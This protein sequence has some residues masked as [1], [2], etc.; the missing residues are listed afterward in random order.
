MPKTAR[1]SS[2]KRANDESLIAH[3]DCVRSFAAVEMVQGIPAVRCPFAMIERGRLAPG[4]LIGRT[5]R[6]EPS[7][8]A[9]ANVNQFEVAVVTVVTEF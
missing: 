7:I 6:L 8:G 5:I 4:K 2:R 9:P 3:A 1:V